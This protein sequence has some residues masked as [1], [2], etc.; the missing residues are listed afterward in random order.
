MKKVGKAARDTDLQGN[1]P[2]AWGVDGQV[3]V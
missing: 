2:A 1:L 3:V